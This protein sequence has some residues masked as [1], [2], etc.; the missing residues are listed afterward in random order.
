MS[1][2][3]VFGLVCLSLVVIS[4]ATFV[5]CAAM[6]GA[7]TTS[8]EVVAQELLDGKEVAGYEISMAEF[9]Q[10]KV[11]MTIAQV[12][13]IAGEGSELMSDL[14]IAGTTHQIYSYQNSDGSNAMLQF[15]GGKLIGKTQIMLP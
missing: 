14:H 13:A 4:V 3:K 5:G 9:N 2:L 8:K 1:F 10:L 7:G 11:G 15:Q 12:L 6:I